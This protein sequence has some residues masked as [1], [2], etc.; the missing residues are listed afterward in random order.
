MG[1]R[2]ASMVAGSFF[3]LSGHQLEHLYLVSQPS[4]SC[5]LQEGTGSRNKARTDEVESAEL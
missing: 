3:A 4:A 5:G 2:D 1:D